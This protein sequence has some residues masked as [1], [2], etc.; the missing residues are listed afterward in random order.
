MD[1]SVRIAACH[2]ALMTSF[3]FGSVWHTDHCVS[4][5]VCH[6]A[7]ENHI[8]AQPPPTSLRTNWT[9]FQ[10]MF[11]SSTKENY[12]LLLDLFLCVVLEGKW[13]LTTQHGVWPHKSPKFLR[14]VSTAPEERAMHS[15]CTHLTVCLDGSRVM[16]QAHLQDCRQHT[17]NF[18]RTLT[19][20]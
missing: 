14:N 1:Q 20:V 18:T 2:T 7:V 13:P 12:F 3:A 5:S 15:L 17:S 9:L 10:K 11:F 19:H 6:F 8:P 4:F 16:I